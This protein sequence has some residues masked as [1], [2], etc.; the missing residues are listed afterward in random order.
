M[1]KAKVLNKLKV[2]YAILNQYTFLE[3]YENI[4][5]L[6]LGLRSE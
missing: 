5:S 1:R 3:N 2:E 4:S 6:L